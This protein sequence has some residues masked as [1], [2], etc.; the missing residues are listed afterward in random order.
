MPAEPVREFLLGSRIGVLG[1]EFGY[2]VRVIE[3]ILTRISRNFWIR[4]CICVSPGI[5]GEALRT[6]V[7]QR[8]LTD[9]IPCRVS[10]GRVIRV[11]WGIFDVYVPERIAIFVQSHPWFVGLLGIEVQWVEGTGTEAPFLIIGYS[12]VWTASVEIAWEPVPID[13]ATG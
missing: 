4:I 2:R 6:G 13:I 3:G 12:T 1:T 5:V 9:E 11:V 7:P 10:F 8:I